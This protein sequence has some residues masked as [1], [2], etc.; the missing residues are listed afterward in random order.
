[1]TDRVTIDDP[2]V[3]RALQLILS[4]LSN[5]L[6]KTSPLAPDTIGAIDDDT[7]I[8]QGRKV[9]YR[10]P[11][12][13]SKE[14]RMNF[15]SLAEGWHLVDDQTSDLGLTRISGTQFRLNGDWTATFTAGRKIRF[16]RT[17]TFGVV[18]SS[19][20]SGGQTTVT[21]TTSVVP[22]PLDFI[23]HDFKPLRAAQSEKGELPG[24]TAYEDEPNVFTLDQTINKATPKLILQGTEGSAKTI[25]LAESAGMFKVQDAGTD[26]FTVNGGDGTVDTP[27]VDDTSV[28][29]TR[30]LLGKA[31]KL[32]LVSANYS[33]M[34]AP[35]YSTVQAAIDAASA[36][37]T[38]LIMPGTYTEQVVMKNGVNVIGVDRDGVI[39]AHDLEDA[40]RTVEGEGHAVKVPATVADAMLGNLTLKITNNGGLTVTQPQGALWLNGDSARV[41]EVRVSGSYDAGVLANGAST[42]HISEMTTETGCASALRVTG[43]G[44]VAL[45]IDRPRFESRST[46]QAAIWI[47]NSNASVHLFGG[48][49]QATDF[50]AVRLENGVLRMGV[51]LVTTNVSSA[52]SIYGAQVNGGTLE[53]YDTT[54]RTIGASETQRGIYITGGTVRGSAGAVI[55]LNNSSSNTIYGVHVQSDNGAVT[56]DLRGVHLEAL[57]LNASGNDHALYL[58]RT[59]NAVTV[60]AYGGNIVSNR[61]RTV[62]INGNIDPQIYSCV[63][64]NLSGAAAAVYSNTTTANPILTSVTVS[65]STSIDAANA[66]TGVTSVN[67]A[68]NTAVG[69]NVT[70]TAVD[71]NVQSGI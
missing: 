5:Y 31:G 57:N 27:S 37:D 14:G 64:K 20:Y 2:N 44:N 65:G 30:A 15:G 54:W 59:S 48:M 3:R 22:S 42:T 19:S 66:G 38:V 70:H 69:A 34:S 17:T 6:R 40:E 24:T 55:A 46:T 12:Y 33:G 32:R 71:F 68:A 58:D 47:N 53:F 41:V 52:S 39:I 50:A 18:G 60:R 10:K 9:M 51:P 56:L 63:I 26:R 23:D 25:H 45:N 16:N 29:L 49:V 67:V 43:S 36:N 1:V 21:M 11:A 61:G 35:F 13:V 62:Y 4:E 7:K 8:V 28:V